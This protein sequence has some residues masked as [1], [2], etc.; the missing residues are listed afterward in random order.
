MKLNRKMVNA[1]VEIGGTYWNHIPLG[2]IFEELNN[3]GLQA[4]DDDGEPWE[5]ILCGHDGRAF[6]PLKDIKTNKII[7]SGLVL[8]WYRMPSG[9][10]EL[11][12]YFS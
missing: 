7:K 12:I 5:G 11:T 6:F 2:D 4:I 8:I 3:G 9:R 10:F 1:I